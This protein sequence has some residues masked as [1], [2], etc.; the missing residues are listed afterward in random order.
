M[1]EVEV[2]VRRSCCQLSV[3]VTSPFLTNYVLSIPVLANPIAYGARRNPI[4]TFIS[5]TPRFQV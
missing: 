5:I 4:R 2:E 3:I 1:G